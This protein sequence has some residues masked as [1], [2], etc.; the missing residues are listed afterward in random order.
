MIKVPENLKQIWDIPMEVVIR[1]P[2]IRILE[3]CRWG[4]WEAF[5]PIC[6]GLHQE[7]DLEFQT[8]PMRKEHT[9]NL[10][11]NTHPKILMMIEDSDLG[12]PILLKHTLRLLITA[13]DIEVLLE[14]TL[15]MT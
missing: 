12:F 8:I 5:L 6:S 3:E 15:I 11:T 2:E 14:I 1:L 9:E 7:I 13:M 10:E 4:L